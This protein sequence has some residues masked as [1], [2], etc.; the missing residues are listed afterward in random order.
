MYSDDYDGSFRNSSDYGQRPE[1]R[2]S[3]GLATASMVLGIFSLMSSTIFYVAV[4][5]GALAV[6]FALLSRGNGKCTGSVRQP[7]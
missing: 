1:S 5:C 4:P 6:L 7:L 2:R 3:N